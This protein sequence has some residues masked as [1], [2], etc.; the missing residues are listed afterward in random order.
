MLKLE[1]LF[2]SQYLT[3]ELLNEMITLYVKFVENINRNQHPVRLYF[4][5][6]IKFV[7]TRPEVVRILEKDT[8]NKSKSI[9]ETVRGVMGVS[10]SDEL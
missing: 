1:E 5:E 4:M 9:R 7:L 10:E 3:E 2:H 6:K 8:I